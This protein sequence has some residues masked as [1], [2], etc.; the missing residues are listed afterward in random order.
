MIVINFSMEAV[1]NVIHLVTDCTPAVPLE[2]CKRENHQPA[3]MK[4]GI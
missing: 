4:D 2:R 3:D 1:S